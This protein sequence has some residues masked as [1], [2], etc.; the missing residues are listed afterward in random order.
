MKISS[1]P[2]R[3]ITVPVLRSQADSY[4][5]C[6]LSGFAT[7]ISDAISQMRRNRMLNLDT[8]QYLPTKTTT[9]AKNTTWR[10]D[11]RDTV[12]IAKTCHLLMSPFNQL[13]T[14][15]VTQ[16]LDNSSSIQGMGKCLA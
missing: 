13:A 15:E 4:T 11:Y 3:A 8:W 2:K 9:I 7:G 16:P 1:F 6:G 10:H 12:D 5:A 14:P